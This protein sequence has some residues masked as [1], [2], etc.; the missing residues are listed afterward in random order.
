MKQPD[1]FNLLSAS[2]PFTEYTEKLMLYG[3]FV[4]AWNIDATWYEANGRFRKG[5]GE[6]YFNW[7]LGG[8]GIQ[9]VLFASGSSP[10]QFGTTLRCYDVDQDVWVIT[11]MQPYGG[12][13]VHLLGRKKGDRIVQEGI[14]T[15]AHR[16]E[17]WSFSDI[18]PDSFLWLGEVSFDE[19]HTWFLEQE[20]R[21]TRRLDPASAL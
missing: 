11:W 7:I 13:F 21:A 1:V 2:G 16:R 17:R 14:G 9:D 5:K 19:G 3:Q 6:W 12:E 4:G 10:H 8:R 18:T 20:M 15:N